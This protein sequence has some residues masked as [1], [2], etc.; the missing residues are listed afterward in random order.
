MNH[1]SRQAGPKNGLSLSLYVHQANYLYAVSTSAGFRVWENSQL[2][3]FT[4]I[5]PMG[6]RR[7]YYVL[8]LSV[9]PS[10]RLLPNSWTGYFE[11]WWT[12]FAAKLY[13]GQDMKRS[14]LGVKRSEVNI[15]H[16]AGP[17][18]YNVCC[19]MVL[20]RT[21]VQAMLSLASVN[22]CG[23]LRLKVV[24]FTVYHWMPVRL[25]IGWYILV[26]LWSWRKDE[27]LYHL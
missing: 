19:N 7:R 16:E 17:I 3:F 4:V 22:L 15:M 5:R 27:F 10:V 9:R 14:T 11:N 18:T 21:A 1:S 8:G 24:R 26:F 12:E 25:L 13:T 6:K 23:T 2:Y 20:K